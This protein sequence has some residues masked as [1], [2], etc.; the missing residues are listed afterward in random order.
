MSC[1][2]NL[3]CTR[4][5]RCLFCLVL[6]GIIP[7]QL[8]WLVSWQKDASP[9]TLKVSSC[10]ITDLVSTNP[11]IRPSTSGSERNGRAGEVG[12]GGGGG[13]TG[14]TVD[15]SSVGRDRAAKTEDD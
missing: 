7:R 12:E 10:H 9:S 8:R 15:P 14:V 6:S 3:P 4:A 11:S 5:C 2:R 13:E 1:K